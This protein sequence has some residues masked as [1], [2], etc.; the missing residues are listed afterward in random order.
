MSKVRV[1]DIRPSQFMYSYGIGSLIDLPNFSVIVDGLDFW[2][3]D[4]NREQITETRLLHA[5]KYYEPTAKYLI[6]PPLSPEGNVFGDPLSEGST[7]GLPVSVFPSWLYC[8]KCRLLAPIESGVFDF[9]KDLGKPEKNRFVH[10]HCLKNT[11]KSPPPKVIPVRFLAVCENGHLD[12]FPWVEYVHQ[13]QACEHPVLNFLE[14]GLTGEARG[15]SVKC[16]TCG[17]SRQMG[18]AFQRSRRESLPLCKGSHPHLHDI[19]PEGCEFHIRPILLGASNS[20]FPVTLNVI[21]IPVQTN[22]LH[23][24]VNNKWEHLVNVNQESD[25]NFL[26]RT[27][28][29]GNEFINYSN[30]DILEVIDDI[31][32]NLGSVGVP[33]EVPE[34]KKPEWD[35]LTDLT[36][37]YQSDDFRLNPVDI[38]PRLSQ[39]ISRLVLVERLREVSALIG[40]SRLDSVGETVDPDEELSIERVSLYKFKNDC[41]PANETRGEGIFIQFDETA[42]N[43]WLTQTTVVQREEQFFHSH[44]RFRAAHFIDNPESNFPGIRYVLLHSISHAL[45]RQLSL[46]C[47]YPVASLRERIY[48]SIDDP[49]SPMAGILLYTAAPDSE[50]TLGG[51]VEMGRT[52]SFENLMIDVFRNVAFCANDPTCAENEPDILGHTIH[53]AACHACLF[54]PETSCE[55]GNKY[56]DRSLICDTFARSDLNF[57]I[58]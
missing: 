43:R 19:D 41:F 20:W 28:I 34:L 58:S 3:T 9:K 33:S 1:G 11:S 44:V 22:H 38:P 35:T 50:G 31:K 25:I 51:L 32:N 18:D 7:V 13:G 42:I 16:V 8:P 47:G 12:N 54:S 57:F 48:S 53:G 14:S 39:F 4:Q 6:Y 24:L 21:A 45:M 40:F 37:T 56:L 17:K 30:G 46:T 15:V 29:L 5:V 36:R 52:A 49:T 23:E 55:K 26:R 27:G 2:N 10:T